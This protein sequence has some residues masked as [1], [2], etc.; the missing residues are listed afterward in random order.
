MSFK[1]ISGTPFEDIKIYFFVPI[2][3]SIS[4]RYHLWDMEKYAFRISCTD[5]WKIFFNDTKYNVSVVCLLQISWGHLFEKIKYT[6]CRSL[7]RYLEDI[8]MRQRKIFHSYISRTDIWTMSSIR[9]TA[10]SSFI[11]FGDI[12]GTSF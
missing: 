11:F 2:F 3:V 6:V 4:W 5:I 12:T 8:F 9:Q 10:I 7:L 1:D